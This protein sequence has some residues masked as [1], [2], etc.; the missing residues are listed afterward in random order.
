MASAKQKITW[1][2]VEWDKQGHG[3]YSILDASWII[4]FDILEFN[5][6]E[7]EESYVVKWCYGKKPAGGWPVYDARVIKVSGKLKI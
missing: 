2:L 6:G 3:K 1:A 4:N 5:A 7:E